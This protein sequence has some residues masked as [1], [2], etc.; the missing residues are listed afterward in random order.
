[1]TPAASETL[2]ALTDLAR[3]PQPDLQQIQ[4]RLSTELIEEPPSNPFREFRAQTEHFGRVELR[5]LRNGGGLLILDARSGDPFSAD[6]LIESGVF[7]PEVARNIEQRMP[8]GGSQFS[9]FDVGT[10]R[11]CIEAGLADATFRGASLEW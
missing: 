8:G 11:L 4:L 9:F 6:E 7:G 1:M 3:L 5:L 10:T 2:R